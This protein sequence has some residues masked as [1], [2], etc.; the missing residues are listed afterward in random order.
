[1]NEQTK[2]LIDGLVEQLSLFVMDDYNYSMID[3]LALV[4]NSQLYV[5][6]MDTETG[7][8]FQSAAYNYRLLKHEITYGKIA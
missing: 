2:F 8:Y 1:M 5:K 3:A 6:I 7:L 4:Y